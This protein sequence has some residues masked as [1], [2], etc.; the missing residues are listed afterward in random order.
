MKSQDVGKS[1]NWSSKEGQKLLEKVLSSIK[2]PIFLD[3][4]STPFCK[5]SLLDES[6]EQAIIKI[7]KTPY[8]IKSSLILEAD[9]I[10]SRNCS[11]FYFEIT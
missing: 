10:N 1:I 11:T 3:V 2:T 9:Y 5:E 4:E 6:E 8:L 7:I